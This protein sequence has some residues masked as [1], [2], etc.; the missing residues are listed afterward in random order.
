[1]ASVYLLSA[2]AADRI[3]ENSKLRA[4]EGHEEQIHG[5]VG[6]LWPECHMRLLVFACFLFG[7]WCCLTVQGRASS[8][9]FEGLFKYAEEQFEA[10][11]QHKELIHRR[12]M[13]FNVFRWTATAVAIVTVSLPFFPKVWRY[14][15]KRGFCA[16]LLNLIL[17][18][19]T[20]FLTVAWGADALTTIGFTIFFGAVALF[21]G[22]WAYLS[23]RSHVL[24]TRKA[25]TT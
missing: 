23:L 19:T 3:G 8:D 14:T 18:G 9:P 1:M 15:P 10:E 21:G 22:I 16:G 17:S 7:G 2:E 5:D 6:W 11:R 20:C 24:R 12:V 13:L 25:T 4:H